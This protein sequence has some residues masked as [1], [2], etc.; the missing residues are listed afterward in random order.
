MVIY[1]VVVECKS[2]KEGLFS[3]LERFM[4]LSVYFQASG[5][6]VNVDVL[7]FFFFYNVA[8]LQ[9]VVSIA[10]QTVSALQ[11]PARLIFR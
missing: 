2:G 11:Y 4:I 6:S 3:H 1:S 5:Y 7:D 8:C 10:A 9:T